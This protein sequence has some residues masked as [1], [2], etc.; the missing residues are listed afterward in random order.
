MADKAYFLSESDLAVIKEFVRKESTTRQNPKIRHIPEVSQTTTE[1]YIAYSSTGISALNSMMGSGGSG[2]IWSPNSAECDVYS[3]DLDTGRLTKQFDISKTVYNL[4]VNPVPAGWLV[5]SRDKYGNWVCGLGALSGNT[6]GGSGGGSAGCNCFNC[7]TAIQ[8]VIDSTTC[9]YCPNGAPFRYTVDFGTWAAYP[10]LFGLQVLTWS[11]G[12][13]WSSP[14]IRIELGT[15]A[16]TGSPS[17]Y[18]IYQWN[19]V[20]AATTTLELSLVSG[21]DIVGI[22]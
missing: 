18:G 15:Y 14:T 3:I 16:G 1:V 12:C 11:S 10:T 21:T 17:E 6:P 4:S 8:A 5:I 22:I 13:T 7:I 9:S 19:L 20:F 2:T